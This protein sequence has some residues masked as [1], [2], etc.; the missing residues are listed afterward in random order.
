VRLRRARSNNMDLWTWHE[1]A[2]LN[3]GRLPK[4]VHLHLFEG[5]NKPAA[6]YHLE[7]AW[8]SKIHIGGL[9]TG[10]PTSAMETVTM[11]CE[12]IQ[13]VSV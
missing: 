8:P 12:F 4:K 6:R 9:T 10:G 1:A 7:N 13:R 5:R 11:T 2:R 3:P